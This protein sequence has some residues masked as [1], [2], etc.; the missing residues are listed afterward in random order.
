MLDA[1][2]W[3]NITIDSSNTERKYQP[4]SMNNRLIGWTKQKRGIGV[5]NAINGNRLKSS[6]DEDLFD[7]QLKKIR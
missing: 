2:Y 3:S 4:S 5:I 7:Y 1:F 6:N